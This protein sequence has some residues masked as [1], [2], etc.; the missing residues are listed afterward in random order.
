MVIYVVSL[1]T[2]CL[3]YNICSAWFLD[4]RISTCSFSCHYIAITEYSTVKLPTALYLTL[5]SQD[6]C[7]CCMDLSS[8]SLASYSCRYVY[9][10]L[11]VWLVRLIFNLHWVSFAQPSVKRKGRLAMPH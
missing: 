7:G 8:S 11:A 2:R 6:H 3:R 9:N 1:Y 4:I 5:K 10:I